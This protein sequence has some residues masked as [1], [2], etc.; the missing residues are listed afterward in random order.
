[1]LS[2]ELEKYNSS[3]SKDEGLATI[4]KT[5]T[6]VCIVF[7]AI[8][9]TGATIEEANTFLF[10]VKLTNHAGLSI[11]FLIS[12]VYLTARYY[13]YA[14]EY[15]SLVASFWK[16][17][18][19]NDENILLNDQENDDT[20]GLLSKI[21]KF[22]GLGDPAVGH[23]EYKVHGIFKRKISFWV[24]DEHMSYD[25]ERELNKYDNKWT[26]KDISK[27]FIYELFYQLDSLLCRKESLDLYSP[28]LLSTA[29]IISFIFKNEVLKML[30]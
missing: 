11:F 30:I 15:S 13:A 4:R 3:L 8:N 26:R 24:S 18:L 10:K 16:I 27:L 1:M 23:P 9:L 25:A 5:L 19:M 17:R 28:Y 14:R 2:E 12:I 22:P 21:F 29:S 6:I 20:Y 7:L